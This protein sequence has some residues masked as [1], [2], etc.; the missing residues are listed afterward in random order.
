[1]E[2]INIQ[3]AIDTLNLEAEAVKDQ[4]KHL[5]DNFVKAVSLIESSSGRV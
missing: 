1:M 4:I 3:R 5:D 2:Q